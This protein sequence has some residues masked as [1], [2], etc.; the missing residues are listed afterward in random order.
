MITLI[1]CQICDFDIYFD[2]MKD[3]EEHLECYHKKE[4]E[5]LSEN[6]RIKKKKEG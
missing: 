2:N 3:F 5:M 6:N 1:E 4:F